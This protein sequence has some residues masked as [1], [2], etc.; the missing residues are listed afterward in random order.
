MAYALWWTCNMF[1][2]TIYYSTLHNTLHTNRFAIATILA[3]SFRPLRKEGTGT[4]TLVPIGEPALS[5]RMTL[6]ASNLGTFGF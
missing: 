3:V 4:L 5:I 1:T 2:D 6:L